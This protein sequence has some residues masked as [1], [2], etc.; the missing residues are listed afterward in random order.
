MIQKFKRDAPYISK[1]YTKSDNAGCYHTS[2]S[3]EALYRLCQRDNI[4]LLRYDYNEP[5]KGKDQCDRESASAKAVIRSYLKGRKCLRKKKLRNLLLRSGPQKN[6]KKLE[7]ITAIWT[8]KWEIKE[9]I[10]AMEYLR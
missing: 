10:I 3:P 2:Y 1:V 6:R 8:N 9:F 4:Q 5:C 7:F